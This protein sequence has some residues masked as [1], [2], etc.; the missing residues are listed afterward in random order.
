MTS[1]QLCAVGRFLNEEYHKL[2]HCRQVGFFCLDDLS[3]DQEKLLEW[4]SGIILNEDSSGIV[5]EWARH[6]LI[7]NMSVPPLRSRMLDQVL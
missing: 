6:R 7:T 1:L 4:R 2:T 5:G 3:P